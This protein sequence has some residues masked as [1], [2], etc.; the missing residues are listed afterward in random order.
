[1]DSQLNMSFHVLFFLFHRD[2]VIPC[3]HV[4]IPP[5]V[6]KFLSKRNIFS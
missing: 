2:L 5:E 4:V 1:M 3:F 6:T